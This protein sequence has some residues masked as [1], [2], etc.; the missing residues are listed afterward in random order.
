MKPHR[1][2]RLARRIAARD[3]ARAHPAQDPGRGLSRRRLLSSSAALA[4]GLTL[5]PLRPVARATA[6]GTTSCDCGKHVDFVYGDC[7]NSFVG[8]APS[9]A[10]A[11]VG[12]IQF[13]IANAA[14]V[15]HCK[16]Q[17][18]QAAS[19]CR[20][21]SCPDGAVCT[22]HNGLADPT[23]EYKCPPGSGT[24]DCNGHCVS[25][26]D[27]PDNCGSCGHSCISPS[28]CCGGHCVNP[29]ND[30]DNCGKCGTVCGQQDGYDTVCC[31]GSCNI[32]ACCGC[33]PPAE[34]CLTTDGNYTCCQYGCH[35]AV[36]GNVCRSAP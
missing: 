23:C 28:I 3:E 18:D 14:A 19:D 20:Q 6:A 24:T 11:Y 33:A 8:D 31:G 5:R 21:V 10:D 13:G 7:W 16:P 4:A 15:P 26:Q 30:H 17:A 9:D 27:D 34:C 1:L 12:A 22:T 29:D 2:D 36:T 32:P 35:G 25:L